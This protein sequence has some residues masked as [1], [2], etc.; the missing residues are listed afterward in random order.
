MAITIRSHDFY[1]SISYGRLTCSGAMYEGVPLPFVLSTR[2][3]PSEP[4]TVTRPKSPIFTSLFLLNMM[5]SGCGGIKQSNVS[6]GTGASSRQVQWR[7]P[8]LQIPV[9]EILGVDVLHSTDYLSENRKTLI[10]NL[11][12]WFL[13]LPHYP[14]PEGFSGTQLHLNIEVLI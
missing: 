4:P 10:F 3:L 9:D 11:L 7:P 14:C 12:V 13:I 6:F 5:F 2:F 8:H 1:T